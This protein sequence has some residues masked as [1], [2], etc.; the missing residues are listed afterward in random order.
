M[1]PTAA[2]MV[3]PRTGP[4]PSSV[5]SISQYSRKD[6]KTPPGVCAEGAVQHSVWR[7]TG[8]THQLE[9]APHGRWS[10]VVATVSIGG[11]A[12]GVA[13]DDGRVKGRPDTTAIRTARRA[14]R[15]HR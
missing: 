14:E 11:M 2:A 12:G 3:K 6:I 5:R 15:G 13:D 10:D 1:G 4:R 7:P 8:A 9:Q